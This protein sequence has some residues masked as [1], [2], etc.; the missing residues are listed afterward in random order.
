M[1][2]SFLNLDSPRLDSASALKKGNIRGVSEGIF[3]YTSGG[4]PSL[5]SDGRFQ[6]SPEKIVFSRALAEDEVDLDSGFIMLPAAMPQLV[7]QAMKSGPQRAH[8]DLNSRRTRTPVTFEK[9]AANCGVRFT[10][11]S[12]VDQILAIASDWR[13]RLLSQAEAP[14]AIGELIASVQV[15]NKGIRITL[16]VPIPPSSEEQPSTSLLRLSHFVRMK[17][18]R[19]GVEMRIILDGP[20]RAP[21]VDPATSR[22]SP[23]WR[24]FLRSSQKQ[25]PRGAHR[26][27]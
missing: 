16:K 22:G 6:I 5:G 10:E 17:V 21:R 3:A 2:D 7:V 18:K 25:S 12:D 4:N 1:C 23:D 14:A 9:I 13:Q 20:L 26:L 19:R 15:T 24:L 27:G 11:I 8:I